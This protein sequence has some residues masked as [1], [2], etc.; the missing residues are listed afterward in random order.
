MNEPLGEDGPAQGGRK[1]LLIGGGVLLLVAV[2]IGAFAGGGAGSDLE[3][4]R[5]QSPAAAAEAA[6]AKAELPKAAKPET[7]VRGIV[8]S[9]QEATIA[10]RMTARIVAMP[11]GEGDAFPKG[12]LLARFDCSQIQAQL[13]AA[14]AATAAYRKTYETNVE[15]DQYEAV[16]KNE[17]AVSQANL[18]KADAEAKAVAAQLSDCAVYAPFSG[19]VVEEIAHAREVAASGQPLLKI[20][21]GGNL[22]IELIVPSRWLTWLRPGAAFGFRIDET[23]QEITGVVTRLGASVDAVSKTIRVTG[24]IT[25]TSGLVLPG[26]SGSATFPD[27]IKASAVAVPGSASTVNGKSS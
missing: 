23:G 18:G 17:V 13:N 6:P 19:K 27:A 8:Q 5:E 20:Q 7:A 15:L 9:K 11:Y 24:D 12:A 1:K 26:M 2:A 14:H 25:E 3:W 4:S 10:S 21:S 22:E 16:G